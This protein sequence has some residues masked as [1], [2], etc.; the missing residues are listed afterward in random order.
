[1]LSKVLRWDKHVLPGRALGS[2][3]VVLCQKKV[4]D[5]RELLE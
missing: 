2:F 4:V 3:L 5:L 1:M